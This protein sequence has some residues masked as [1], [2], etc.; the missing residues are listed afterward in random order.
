M[1]DPKGIC[2][3]QIDM[4]VASASMEMLSTCFLEEY[5]PATRGAK[6]DEARFNMYG[7]VM[8][9]IRSQLSDILNALEKALANTTAQNEQ[10]AENPRISH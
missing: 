2:E 6:L 7:N 4:T 5:D 9:S 8:V 3:I 10:K 1:I